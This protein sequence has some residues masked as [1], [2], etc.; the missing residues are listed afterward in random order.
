[1][2]PS[3]SAIREVSLSLCASP[4]T[5]RVEVVG[6]G[7]R[8]TVDFVTM[9]VVTHRN[10]GLPSFVDCFTANFRT[11]GSLIRSGT[12]VACGIVTGRVKRY[13]GVRGL[14]REFYE[15]LRKGVA[16]PV[17]PEDGLLNLRLMDQIGRL[18]RSCQTPSRS[19]P[20]LQWPP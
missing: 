7:G 17:L 6:T 15:S 12:G 5:N 1:M 2:I 10:N 13:M 3:A 18:R 16:P 19:P 20:C 4:E 11:A 8:I 14:I 9:T